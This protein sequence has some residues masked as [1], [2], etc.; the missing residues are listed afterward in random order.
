MK[1][2]FYF[3]WIFI[4]LSLTFLGSCKKS[5]Q[6][7]PNKLVDT[8]TQIYKMGFDTVGI[9]DM[10]DYYLV[11][12]DIGIKK[13]SLNTMKR[14]VYYN[15]TIGAS[16][17]ALENQNNIT[18]RIDETVPTDGS[19]YDYHTAVIMAI[20][21]WNNLG[22]NIHF[23]LVSTP[24]ADITIRAF[25]I[26]LPSGD[27]YYDLAA[28]I[29]DLPKNGYPASTIS[30][31]TTCTLDINTDEKKKLII[32]H[33]LGHTVNLAHTQDYNQFYTTKIGISPDDD[34]SS[35]FNAGI[36]GKVLSDFS[37]WDMYAILYLY[38]GSYSSEEKNGTFTRNN[39]GSGYV[40]STVTYTVPA[41]RYTSTISQANADIKAILDVNTNGQSFANTNGTCI[42]APYINVIVTNPNPN[43]GYMPSV[44]FYDRITG[45]N[46]FYKTFYSSYGSMNVLPDIYNLHITQ[47]NSKPFTVSI[48]GYPTKTGQTVIYD[49]VTVHNYFPTITI[50]NR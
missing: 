15:S 38:P 30:I 22:S 18:V 1:Q 36:A 42:P 16:K 17:V 13:T 34:A 5:D 35:V 23:N 49:N 9:I 39:C 37:I 10:G 47:T 33:E 46:V 4:I 43:Q 6:Y 25:D 19:N 40:G 27:P 26:F 31:N 2:L 32:V 14:Q 3:I 45:Q 21:Q 8:M 7:Y 28:Q 44:N 24:T 12:G 41:G 48:S 29:D 11:A 50:D 20:E